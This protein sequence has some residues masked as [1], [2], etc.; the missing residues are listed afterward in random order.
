MAIQTQNPATGEII[1][2]FAAH[3]DAQ[4]DEKLA[5]SYAAYTD[6]R[7]WSFETRAEHLRRAG[8]ILH[9]DA[10][11]LGEIVT[12]EMG[13]TLNI[14]L[15]KSL[16]RTRQNPTAPINR[17]DRFL[18]SCR[19]IIRFGKSCASLRLRLWQVIAAC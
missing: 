8:Q 16:K 14:W 10:Q 2:T 13:K 11:T 12:L 15:M 18:R 19:G 5:K 4:V 1:K 9:E 3:T 17:L 6:L 7:L